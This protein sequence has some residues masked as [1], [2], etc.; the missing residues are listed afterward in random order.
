MCFKSLN[1]GKTLIKII[2]FFKEYFFVYLFLAVLGLCCYG[3]A[4]SGC[5]KWGYS[6]AVV[7]GLL[8]CH[9]F[10]CCRAWAGEC[11]GSVV[12]AHGLGCLVSRGIFW[13][14][15]LNWCP[16]HWQADS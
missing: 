11:V 16:M 15:G 8:T 13:D 12:V 5:Q 4:F 10:S 6:L 14:Q 1:L 7:H 2:F 9:G 3:G